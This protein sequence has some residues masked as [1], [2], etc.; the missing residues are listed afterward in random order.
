[1]KSLKTIACACLMMAFG[2]VGTAGAEPPVKPG[3]LP[4]NAVSALRSHAQ[5]RIAEM[6]ERRAVRPIA[7][8]IV[9]A[10]ARRLASRFDEASLRAVAAGEDVERLVDEV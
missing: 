1:M 10:D 3:S 8:E 2:M 4:A 9:A 7:P 6:L 5:S